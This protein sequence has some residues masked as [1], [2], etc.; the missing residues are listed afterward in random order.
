MEAIIIILLIAAIFMLPKLLENAGTGH[1][2]DT[3]PAA[4][5]DD[6]GST[7]GTTADDPDIRHAA[8]VLAGFHELPPDQIE[9]WKQGAD[10]EAAYRHAHPTF[11][12]LWGQSGWGCCLP[13][14]HLPTG[15]KPHKLDAKLRKADGEIV[16]RKV[17]PLIKLTVDSENGNSYPLTIAAL[18]Q[19]LPAEEAARRERDR[20]A[21]DR[22]TAEWERRNIEI[23]G[24]PTDDTPRDDPRVCAAPHCRLPP[25]TRGMCSY[26]HR[27]RR[28]GRE[29]MNHIW[30][31]N[32]TGSD[33]CD[34]PGCE[35][36]RSTY[37]LC[38]PHRK[39]WDEQGYLT[40]IPYGRRAKRQTA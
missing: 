31:R 40:D 28:E 18:C 21:R 8:A 16:N 19:E 38:P 36:K 2:R 37:G 15:S 35:R 1:R 33:R 12:N 9:E 22:A 29:L 6:S 7:A 34:M 17:I 4:A 25:R 30:R 3:A 23:S 10:L 24:D 13:G 32:M 20:A 27:Q 39:Q 11:I 5:L 14:N 26:H